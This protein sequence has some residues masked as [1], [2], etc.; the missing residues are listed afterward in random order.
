MTLIRD[1]LEDARLAK[2]ST[3][4]LPLAERLQ[5]WDAAIT[6]ICGPVVTDPGPQFDGRIELRR[7][8]D[9]E[10]SRMIHNARSARRGRPQIAAHDPGVLHVVLQLSGRC[11]LTQA[12]REVQLAPG[13]MT[14]LDSARPLDIQFVQKNAQVWLHFPKKTIEPP[15]LGPS[16][17]LARRVTGAAAILLGGLIRTAFGNAST[18]TP[19]QAR[20]IRDA[21]VGLVGQTW[22]PPAGRTGEEDRLVPPIVHVIQ[23]YIVSN[24]HSREL[25]PAS[26]AR[27]HGL[28]VRH[29]HRLFG[30]TG[31]SLAR[32]IRRSRLDRCAADLLDHSLAAESVTRISYQWGFEDSAHFSRAFKAEFGQ[33]PRRYRME[34]Q[35]QP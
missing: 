31:L 33:S 7:V 29:L 30:M 13:D 28:S 16:P 11:G 27:E 24:L 2:F 4:R 20:A 17:L 15:D 12:G 1:P 18:W 32:W 26:I 5:A 34:R 21:L 14:M 35:F 8:A 9:L 25:S 10:A 6:Q 3:R 19:G 23:N 22:W